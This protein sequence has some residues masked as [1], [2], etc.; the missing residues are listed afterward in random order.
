MN[1]FIKTMFI[2]FVLQVIARIIVL[3][4]SEWPA[5]RN[6]EAGQYAASTIIVA[7]LAIWAAFVIW[8]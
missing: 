2:Y 6:Y 7:T 1:T 3:V 5:K 4:T 8:S